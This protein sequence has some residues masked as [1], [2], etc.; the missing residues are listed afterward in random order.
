MRSS[1]FSFALVAIASTS[2]AA[3]IMDRAI[4]DIFRVGITEAGKDFNKLSA[5]DAE[6]FVSLA[7]AAAA[8]HQ[9][10]ERSEDDMNVR[11]IWSLALSFST[12]SRVLRCVTASVLSP[13]MEIIYFSPFET[14]RTSHS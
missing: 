3:P 14:I 7:A 4:A 6:D 11:I 8:S 9:S 10:T 12:S 5:R 1:L 2:Y 13:K